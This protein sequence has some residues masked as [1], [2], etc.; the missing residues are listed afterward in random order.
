MIVPSFVM[1]CDRVTFKPSSNVRIGPGGVNDFKLEVKY[2]RPTSDYRH[3]LQRDMSPWLHRWA[4]EQ[5]SILA[6]TA[7]LVSRHWTCKC[8]TTHVLLG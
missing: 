3:E 1:P 4:V 5:R 6:A 8:D 7:I 2:A